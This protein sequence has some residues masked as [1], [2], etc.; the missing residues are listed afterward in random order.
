MAGTYTAPNG[1][2]DG[3]NDYGSS[4]TIAISHATHGYKVGQILERTG[5]ATFAAA[6]ADDAATMNGQI[7]I[8]TSIADDSNYVV[9]L[10]D[11]AV[12]IANADLADVFEGGTP[13]VGATV[14][15][16]DSAAGK[17]TATPPS[18]E[19]SFVLAIGSVFSTTAGGGNN[20]VIVHFNPSLIGLAAG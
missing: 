17:M 6:Q 16:S 11:R 1:A 3:T 12:Q 18:A 9:G 14:Y 15:L 10:N 8:I 7:G 13:A 5:S 20:D 4:A 2:N 19:G